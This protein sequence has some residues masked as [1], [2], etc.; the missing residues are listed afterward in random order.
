MLKR[1]RTLKELLMLLLLKLEGPIGRYRLK[2]MMGLS[3]REGVVRQMLADLQKDGYVSA[4]RPGS[5]LTA[6][7]QDLLNQRLNAYNIVD[8]KDI[9]LQ[10]LKTGPTSVGIHLKGKA[11]AIHSGIEQRDAAVRAGST[12]AT[13]LMFK[14][15]LLSIPKV[16]PNLSSEKP[17]LTN[18]LYR[19]FNLTE[20]DA[21]IIISAKNR[22]RAME[23][24]LAATRILA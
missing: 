5:M 21:L 9:D 8:I 10:E 7:G 12:G 4:S 19:A 24:A 3:E 11:D 22:W 16:Y 6:E 15:G 1:E 2:E 23:G 20:G 14:N 17:E 18:Q 13:I